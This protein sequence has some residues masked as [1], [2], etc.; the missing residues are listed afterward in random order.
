MY[1]W[2]PLLSLVSR[3]APPKFNA[4]M[5]GSSFL[6]LFVANNLI[7]WVGT[8]YEQM[9]PIA[10]WGL[11]AGIGA[12]GGVLAFVFARTGGRILEPQ[13]VETAKR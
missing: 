11:H 5:M 13:P 2:P 6:V 8:F 9:T 7:G 12:A 4:T 3:A 1:F 10:F